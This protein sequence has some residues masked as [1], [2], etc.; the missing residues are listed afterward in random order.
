MSEVHKTM[1]V[2]VDTLHQ[3]T[4]D[5]CGTVLDYDQ[6][7]FFNLSAIICCIILTFAFGMTGKLHQAK[8]HYQN[9]LNFCWM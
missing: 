1:R 7:H 6:A 2:W 3:A 4:S 5:I 9:P 8:M